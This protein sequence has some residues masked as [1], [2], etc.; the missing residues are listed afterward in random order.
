MASPEIEKFADD[1]M[2]EI[3]MN[4]CDLANIVMATEGFTPTDE[5]SAAVEL[6]VQAGANAALQW[7]KDHKMIAGM[8]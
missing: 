6:G 8:S 5:H 2:R 7:L 4:G 1:M 3:T